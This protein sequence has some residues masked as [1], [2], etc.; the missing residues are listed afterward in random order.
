MKGS[1]PEVDCTGAYPLSEKAKL[2]SVVGSR[3]RDTGSAIIAQGRVAPAF[4]YQDIDRNGHGDPAGLDRQRTECPGRIEGRAQGKSA[5]SRC[6]RTDTEIRAMIEQNRV[7]VE[8]LANVEK[9]TFISGSSP[10]TLARAAQ[11]VSMLHRNLREEDRRCGRARAFEERIGETRKRIR[12]Q[13][14][15]VGQ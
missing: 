13:P 1:R 4:V 14:A 2:I 3:R 9:I 5:R 6:L 15:P 12:Q 8:R 7:A 11:R 10:G